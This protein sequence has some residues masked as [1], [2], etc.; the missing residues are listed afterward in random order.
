MY[1]LVKRHKLSNIIFVICIVLVISSKG[2]L[3]KTDHSK[4]K[5]WGQATTI[6][7]VNK[8]WYIKLNH[9]LKGSTINKY[10]IFIEDEAGNRIE[11]TI[12][13]LNDNK[14]IKILPNKPYENLK[15]YRIYINDK[16]QNE[17]GKGLKEPI[18]YE[19]KVVLKDDKSSIKEV[20]SSVNSLFTSISV[21]TSSNIY[22]VYAD[23][24]EAKYKGNNYYNVNIIGKKIGDKVKI[25]TYNSENKLVDEIE[26]TISK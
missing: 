13:M 23:N 26:Y 8:E 25:K 20:N 15:S 12:S 16:V 4:F 11:T 14:T 9:K 2:V 22:K 21:K 17:E 19:F 6:S 1:I 10:N 24:I 5:T 7:D 18:F 3:A